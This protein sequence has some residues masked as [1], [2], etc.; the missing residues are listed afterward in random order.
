[1]QLQNHGNVTKAIV[2]EW[3]QPQEM[4]VYLMYAHGGANVCEVGTTV[5][6]R[7]ANISNLPLAW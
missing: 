7:W 1:M 6:Q 4:H 2:Q 5:L 3:L